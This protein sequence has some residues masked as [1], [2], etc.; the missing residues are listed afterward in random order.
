METVKRKKKGKIFVFVFIGIIMLYLLL[1]TILNFKTAYKIKKNSLNA[2]IEKHEWGYYS[3]GSSNIIKP[4]VDLD[5]VY[6]VN[7]SLWIQ[8]QERRYIIHGGYINL[9]LMDKDLVV[10]GENGIRLDRSFGLIDETETDPEVI[11]LYYDN[12]DEIEKAIELF[13]EKYM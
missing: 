10:Y 3:A 4:Y 11:D 9:F 1:L 13:R 12:L 5:V 8:V 7:D 6:E 2:R